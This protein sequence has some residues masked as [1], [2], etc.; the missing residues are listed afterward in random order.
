MSS[1]LLRPP[2]AVLW[3]SFELWK[4]EICHKDT[5]LLAGKATAPETDRANVLTRWLEPVFAAKRS[6]LLFLP[7]R[8]CGRQ[9]AWTNHYTWWRQN[10]E[11][12]ILRKI[13]AGVSRQIAVFW[14]IAWESGNLI[15]QR[16]FLF[17]Q[18][19]VTTLFGLWFSVNDENYH[20]NTHTQF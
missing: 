4:G 2:L 1:T 7:N 9:F 19:I 18:R 6:I 10:R 13:M 15:I 14:D 3:A 16:T 12:A 20:A 11:H 5:E 8:N 17:F